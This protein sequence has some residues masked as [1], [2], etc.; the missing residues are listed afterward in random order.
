MGLLYFK[1][2]ENQFKKYT[3]PPEKNI[4][5]LSIWVR[6]PADYVTICNQLGCKLDD[7]IKEFVKQF[8]QNKGLGRWISTEP[9][10]TQGE[11]NG[12]N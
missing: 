12:K 2:K 10:R 7:P 9:S 1:G 6:I 5:K 4:I 8:T 11:T 3:A